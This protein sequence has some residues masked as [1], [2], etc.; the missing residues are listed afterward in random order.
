MAKKEIK[1]YAKPFGKKEKVLNYESKTPRKNV[2]IITPEVAFNEGKAQFELFA[3]SS[4]ITKT[5]EGDAVAIDK[6][7]LKFALLNEEN[8]DVIELFEVW[9]VKNNSK[10][11]VQYS[12]VINTQVKVKFTK[13]FSLIILFK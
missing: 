4:T 7:Q 2:T 12:E 8:F 5:G 10:F 9:N 13:N 1:K 6:I 3:P 11:L